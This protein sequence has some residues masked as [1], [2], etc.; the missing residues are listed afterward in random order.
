MWFREW[1]TNSDQTGEELAALWDCPFYETSA[2]CKKNNVEAFYE[3]VREIN[4]YKTSNDED[5]G[6]RKKKLKNYQNVPYYKLWLYFM[7]YLTY[8]C[9]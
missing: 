7:H 1:S 9:F 5:D 2:K 8:F 6:K 3:V 4:R